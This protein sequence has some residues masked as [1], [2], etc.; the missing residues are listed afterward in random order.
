MANPHHART[1]SVFA[2]VG[3]LAVAIPAIAATHEAAAANPRPEKEI[4][5]LIETWH[6]PPEGNR[7]HAFVS[8]LCEKIRG[9]ADP[10]LRLRYFRRVVDK[11]LAVR[12]E[13]VDGFPVEVWGLEPFYLDSRDRK[14]TLDGEHRFMV[15]VMRNVYYALRSSGLPLEDQFDPVFRFAA[16]VEAEKYRLKT[17]DVGEASRLLDE[18]ERDLYGRTRNVHDPVARRLLNRFERTFYRPIR[19][20]EEIAEDRKLLDAAIRRAEDRKMKSFRGTGGTRLW[21]IWR[22]WRETRTP[23]EGG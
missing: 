2:L 4:E 23:R 11:A 16:K 1:A 7:S 17:L 13:D 22:D 9:L 8:V 3:L 19:T 18:A 15:T 12:F 21:E 6:T 10:E 20:P 5:G 14:G